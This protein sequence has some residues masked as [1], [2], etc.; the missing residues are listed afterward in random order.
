[1]ADAVNAMNAAVA[2]NETP[3]VPEPVPTSVWVKLYY[4][5]DEKP[6]NNSDAFNQNYGK[7]AASACCR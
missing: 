6:V 5:G 7:L 4:E 3:V 2:D 1:M